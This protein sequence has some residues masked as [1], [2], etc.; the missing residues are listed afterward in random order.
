M[1]GLNLAQ[2]GNW[3]KNRLKR[4]I[5]SI[6]FVP[7]LKTTPCELDTRRYVNKI[8]HY[9]TI[10][11][12]IVSFLIT[13]GLLGTA[14]EAIKNCLRSSEGHKITSDRQCNPSASTIDKKL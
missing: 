4:S 11:T 7:L 5:F 9:L 12:G 6:S 13:F 3:P 2:C 1:A 10:T 8:S 14:A